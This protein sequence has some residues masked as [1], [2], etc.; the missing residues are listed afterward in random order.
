M[1]QVC[2][3]DV[4]KDSVFV[5]IINENGVVFQEKYG[6][7]TPELEQMLAKM[8][9]YHVEEVC[10]ESTSIYWMPV[11][12]VLENYVNLKLVNPYFIK[13]LPG[14][15]SDVKEGLHLFSVYIPPKRKTLS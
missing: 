15:K 12:R 14:K 4:H 9:E 6:V 3:L 1:R 5:C 8:L 10:M 2:G 11:W 13:Q 7:L